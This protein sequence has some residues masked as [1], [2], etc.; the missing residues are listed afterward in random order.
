[1]AGAGCREPGSDEARPTGPAGTRCDT[2]PTRD[3]HRVS[4]R[5]HLAGWTPT[6]PGTATHHDRRDPRS[7][8]PGRPRGRTVHGPRA[9]GRDG[10]APRPH[11][12][13]E[14]R[15][16]FPRR[17]PLGRSAARS[18]TARSRPGAGSAQQGEWS[19][20]PFPG[21]A[22]P[23]DREGDD[24]APV[25]PTVRRPRPG[26]RR[27]PSRGD[28]RGLTGPAAA[29]RPGRAAARR[30]RRPGV[31]VR[32]RRAGARR[33]R[34]APGHRGHP[35]PPRRVA[36]R[37]DHH[38]GSRA[39]GGPRRPPRSAAGRPPAGG[40]RDR[41]R[42]PGLPLAV[43]DGQVVGALS[44]FGREPRDWSD[45]DV[46]LLRQLG[47]S[48]AVELQLAAQVRELESSRLAFELA[49]DAAGIGSFD[50][51]LVTG[52]LVWDDR[53][54]E[55]MGFARD[56]FDETIDAFTA[57][58]PPRRP[59]P[60]DGGAAAGHRHGGRVRRRVPGGAALRRDPLGAGP[61]PGPGRRPRR[62]RPAGGG[63]LRHHRAAARRCAGRPRH[64][65]G[66]VRVLHPRPRLALHLPQRR[67]RAGAADHPGGAPRR[68][69]LGGLPGRRR[70][71]LRGP[72]PRGDGHRCGAGV[73]GLLPR[74]PRRV[75]RGPGV[76]RPGRAVG[77]LPRRDRAPRRRGPRPPERGAAA[78]GR[79]HD[80]GD[81]RAAGHR[82]P[83]RRPRCRRSPRRWSR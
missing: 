22:P 63:R 5:Q 68:G 44:A 47:D 38:G 27:R 81:G 75:V 40:R 21:R 11:I 67:G 78:P 1:M 10:R 48:V 14:R 9:R 65:V 39:G 58:L 73:R 51:D 77:L 62:R 64:G 41:G 23:A 12:P 49:I 20:G 3:H 55:L 83:A 13:A 30:R 36:V 46:A 7:G 53:L 2:T 15:A 76:A 32:R 56:S 70:Q 19:G 72:L 29:H 50:W 33:H 35:R 74:S 43:F 82:R 8:L 25:D 57:R 17:P 54:K 26:G 60:D 66:E 4:D 79:R 37:R 59:G 71:R 6:Q 31:A 61:R 80:G 69:D 45:A 34:P 28:R 18:A 52:R 42:L 24:V 16:P